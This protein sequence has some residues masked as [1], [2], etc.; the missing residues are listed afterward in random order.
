MSRWRRYLGSVLVALALAGVPSG[1][2][3]QWVVLDP[4]NLAQNIISAVESVT[5]T[6][7]QLQ[8]IQYQLQ[9]LKKLDDATWRDIVPMITALDN[10]MIQGASL[11]YSLGNLPQQFDA[12]FGG[13]LIPS[14]FTLLSAGQRARAERA[15]ATTRAGLMTARQHAQNF[16]SNYVKLQQIKQQAGSINGH[17]EALELTSTIQAYVAEELQMMRQMQIVAVNLEA[18]RQ[19]AE[20]QKEL[21]RQ[22][23]FRTLMT[24]TGQLSAYAPTFSFRVQ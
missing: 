7:Q 18:I 2:S 24:N 22:A 8:Q 3:A 15:L 12:V 11:G 13:Y 1:A 5:Q 4:T 10:A 23:A 9:A 20:A 19:A 17:Q 16:Q 21:E 14:D 6:A